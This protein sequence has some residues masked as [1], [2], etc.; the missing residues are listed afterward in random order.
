[1]RPV[2]ALDHVAVVE[3]EAREQAVGADAEQAEARGTAVAHLG[4]RP[5]LRQEPARV[6]ERAGELAAGGEPRVLAGAA[7]AVASLP[8]GRGGA[9]AGGCGP[10]GAGALA[11][12]SP[13]SP[14][15]SATVARSQPMLASRPAPTRSPTR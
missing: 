10:A 4:H 8:G 3:A 13:A 14:P 6:A 2:D 1:G 5:E 12:S 15:S 11:I 9:W 7:E